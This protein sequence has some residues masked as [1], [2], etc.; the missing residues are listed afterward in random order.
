MNSFA[1]VRF[2]NH[3]KIT[4]ILAYIISHLG[5]KYVPKPYGIFCDKTVKKNIYI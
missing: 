5:K 1:N 3:T 4:Q 2:N